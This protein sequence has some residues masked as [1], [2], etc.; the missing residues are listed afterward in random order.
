VI[1]KIQGNSG[2]AWDDE[3]G[4]N[5]QNNAAGSWDAFVTEC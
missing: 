3:K 5:I 4:A 2:W 1:V